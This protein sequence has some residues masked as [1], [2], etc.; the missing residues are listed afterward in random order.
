MARVKYNEGAAVFF[1]GMSDHFKLPIFDFAADGKYPKERQKAG[2]KHSSELFA[3]EAIRFL[4]GYK[5]DQPFFLYCAFWAPHDPRTA[6]AE[7]AR[8][9]D[10]AKLKLPRS[11]LPEHPFDNGELKVRDELLAPFPRKAE[12]I[13]RHTAD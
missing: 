1:G 8:L 10:P 2:D 5:R 4:E 9:Y 13:R 11:F 12:A 3:D 7:Y 6:P